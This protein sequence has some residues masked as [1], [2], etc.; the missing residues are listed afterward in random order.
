MIDGC[1]HNRLELPL[2][3]PAT[4]FELLAP[5]AHVLDLASDRVLELEPLIGIRRHGVL[6]RLERG[7]LLFDLRPLN[8]DLR[9]RPLALCTIG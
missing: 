5:L 3:L 6:R 8:L 2:M 4:L 1:S 9:F 7:F